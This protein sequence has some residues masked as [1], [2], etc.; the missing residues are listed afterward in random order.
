MGDDLSPAA[1]IGP[2]DLIIESVGGK[3]LA[4]VLTQIAV[5]RCLRLTWSV[6]RY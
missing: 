3:M 6:S 1:N 4:T 2:Y 5:R